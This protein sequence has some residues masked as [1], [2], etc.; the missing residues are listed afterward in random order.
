MPLPLFALFLAAFAFGTTEFVIAGIL[1]DVAQ[2]L[3]VS[4]PFAGSL[5][6]GYALG[7]AIGGPLLTMATRQVSRRTILIALT[8]AFCL[9]QIACALA[10]DFATMLLFRVATAVAH[11]AY[12]GIAMVVAVGLVPQA[13]RGRAVAVILAGL[14]VSNIIGVPVGA[15]IG[16]LWG[17]RTTF[18]AMTSVG[19]LA[20]AAIWALIPS[21]KA[22]LQPSGHLSREVRVLGRQQVWTSLIIMLALMIGQMVPF[23]YITPLLREVTGL[24]AMLIPWVLLLNGV[25]A[26][27]GVLL[28]GRLSDWKLMPSLIV[29]L[30]IQA[31]ILVVLYLVSPYPLLMT[32]TIFIWGALNFAI[33]APVQARILMWTADA[34][35]LASSLIPSGFNIGIAIA[36]SIGAALLEGGFGYRS[37]PVLGA[38]ALALACGVAILSAAHEKRIGALPP[39]AALS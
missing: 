32:V 33:G 25:G 11:G 39:H 18:W 12:F 27:L 31:A 6:S 9:G 26:T 20:L 35:S 1:P 15:A 30:A 5:V 36:A 7:I 2:G 3:D 28:G 13:F 23:T 17:W 4:I 19:V 24:D 8:I 16:G 22:E 21:T 14:T 10:P 37:L 34:P 29:M 38:I